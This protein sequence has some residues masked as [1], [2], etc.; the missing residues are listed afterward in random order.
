ME[1]LTFP[2]LAITFLQAKINYGGQTQY[3][4]KK[5]D[6]G[7]RMSRWVQMQRC[8]DLCHWISIDNH[9]KEANGVAGSIVEMFPRGK[10]RICP[11]WQLLK[12][13]CCIE[14]NEDQ[15]SIR[16]SG[17]IGQ[18]CLQKPLGYLFL[19]HNRQ[20]IRAV[21][22]GCDTVSRTYTAKTLNAGLDTYWSAILLLSSS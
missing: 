2:A 12:K 14:V 10:Q 6:G 16:C 7:N 21:A 5:G 19:L 3:Q 9:I 22:M 15:N 4:M 18:C 1:H 17:E 11:P 8:L 20:C 13:K